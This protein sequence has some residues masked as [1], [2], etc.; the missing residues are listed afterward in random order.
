MQFC[1]LLKSH[2]V[3]FTTAFIKHLFHPLC[4]EHVHLTTPTAPCLVL[5]EPSPADGELDMVC[6]AGSSLHSAMLKVFGTVDA[7]VNHQRGFQAAVWM[8]PR[9]IWAEEWGPSWEVRRIW[10][11]PSYYLLENVRLFLVINLLL[12]LC[13]QW[14][15]KYG[16]CTNRLTHSNPESEE[17]FLSV[18]KKIVLTVKKYYCCRFLY[19]LYLSYISYLSCIVYINYGM[20]EKL[21][22]Q[23]ITTNK[24]V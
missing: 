3:C 22:Q 9:E 13:L 24:K 6:H 5:W 1:S 2:S 8:S 16:T 11:H 19:F 20:V 7:P 18:L 10:K 12:I 17:P 15:H 21:K 14:M 23:W 4:T